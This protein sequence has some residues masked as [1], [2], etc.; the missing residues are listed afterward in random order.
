MCTSINLTHHKS[1][2]LNLITETKTKYSD[3]FYYYKNDQFIGQSL[4]LYGEYCEPEV[5]VLS[6]FLTDNAVVYDIGGNIGVHAVAFATLAP[7]AQIY[8][9]EP[10]PLN[11]DLLRHNT[12]HLPNV[13]LFNKA[14][15]NTTD[16]VYISGFDPSIVGNYG[17]IKVGALGT[18][19]EQV[20]L[21]DVDI[22]D[23][24][25][26]KIDVEG[27]EY[28]VLQGC[29]EKIARAQP[30]IFYESNDHPDFIPIYE[31]LASLGYQM[32][33]YPVHNYNPNNFKQNPNNIF[34]NG[35]V[36][37]IIALPA[38]YS[39]QIGV[40]RVMG[41]TDTYQAYARRVTAVSEFH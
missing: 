26:M 10:N 18:R 12:K 11:Y 33:W 24:T 34:L 39:Q 2:Q 13:T 35:G 21:D 6:Q 9:F 1:D 17:D 22:P 32:Y 23:P 8:S 40:N 31:L 15:G 28:H 41:A 37:N 36:V 3:R 5:T 25:V 4:E 27:Y 20:R 29:K 16:D 14:V 19:V 7:Q 30:V 38:R